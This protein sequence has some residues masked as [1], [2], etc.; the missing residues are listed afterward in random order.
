[1]A[2]DA[3]VGVGYR[4]RMPDN[5][6]VLRAYSRITALRENLG[7]QQDFELHER[8][9]HEYHAALDQL[10][11]AGFEMKEF[12]VPE[13]ELE[14]RFLG[15]NAYDKRY[16]EELYVD[17]LLLLIKMDSVLKYFE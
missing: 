11:E 14:K 8:Y 6:K 7:K 1:M 15:G 17:R 9:V 10:E 5:D 13:K 4:S 16:S 12:R 3:A 2:V